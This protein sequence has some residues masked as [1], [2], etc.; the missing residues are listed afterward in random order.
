M[1]E[2]PELHGKYVEETVKKIVPKSEEQIKYNKSMSKKPG[3]AR[4]HNS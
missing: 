4:T 1:E 2:V 3:K